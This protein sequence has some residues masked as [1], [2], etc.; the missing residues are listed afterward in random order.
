VRA[1]NILTYKMF[2]LF[3]FW[4]LRTEGIQKTKRTIFVAE[5]LLHELLV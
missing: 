2:A 3:G 5:L 4:N 1:Y